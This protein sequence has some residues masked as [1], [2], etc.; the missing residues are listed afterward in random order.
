MKKK[1]FKTTTIVLFVVLICMQIV[2][3]Y[4]TSERQHEVNLQFMNSYISLTTNLH[5]K[6]LPVDG[7]ALHKLDIENT[8][9]K[10]TM[11]LLYNDTSFY[12]DRYVDDIISTLNLV[13]GC[14]AI[15]EIN[16]SKELNDILNDFGQHLQSDTCTEEI[17]KST[18]EALEKAVDFKKV[19]QAKSY[20]IE[21]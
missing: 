5:N 1:I 10:H 3:I 19:K 13:S 15:H 21:D 2:S 18:W 17:S 4:K 16:Y 7:Y 11:M 14:D 9:C 6:T 8:K 20:I 12:K